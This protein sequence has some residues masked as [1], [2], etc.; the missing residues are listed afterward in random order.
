MPT[1]ILRFY[2]ELN[3]C[4]P[5]ELRQRPFPYRFQGEPSVKDAIE[6]L[7]VPHVEVDL[8][9]VNGSSVDFGHRL[10]HGDRVAVYPMFETLDIGQVQRVRPEPLRE[11]SFL[12]D[13]HLGKL[14]RLLRLLG[15]DT[16]YG[17]ELDDADIAEE[18]ARQHRIVLT[19]DRGLL[20]RSVVRHGYWVRSDDPEE[21]AREVV[22]RFDLAGKARPFTLCLSCGGRLDPVDKD[23]V[24]P[25]IPPRVRAWRDEFLLCRD[26]RKLY[27]RGTHHARLASTVERI[28]RMSGCDDPRSDRTSGGG[29]SRR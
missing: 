15:F 5:G 9:L 8:V 25:R 2:A 26:C 21:Q 10:C 11:V 19:R 16:L 28:L 6:A 4:L 14:A 29:C 13:A 12:A 27:W 1:A 18:A 22:R 3:D 20:K 24:L 17:R 23:S 7:G